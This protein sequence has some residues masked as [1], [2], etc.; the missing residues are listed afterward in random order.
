[1]VSS[2]LS[3]MRCSSETEAAPKLEVKTAS[4]SL[5]K[6]RVTVVISS[7]SAKRGSAGRRALWALTSVGSS[8]KR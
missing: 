1:M 6:R 7:Q 4:R 8:R 5:G 2:P 3:P